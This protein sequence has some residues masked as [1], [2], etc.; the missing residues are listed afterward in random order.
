MSK[1]DTHINDK[2]LNCLIQ[3]PHTILFDCN[4]SWFNL[5]PMNER[6]RVAICDDHKIFR[7]GVISSLKP[8]NNIEIVADTE[9]GTELLKKIHSTSPDIVLLD[10]NMPEMDGLEVC[11]RIKS[12]YPEVHVIGLSL[13]EQVYFIT[14][15]FKAGA[16]S[17][18]LK[19]VDPEEM[20][21][22]M[23]Q[24]YIH[25]FYLHDQIPVDLVKNLV[26]MDHP[27]VGLFIESNEELKERDIALLR[28]ITAEYTNNEIAEKLS[29]SPVTIENYRNQL[30]KKTGARNTAGLVTYAIRK[31]YVI[32]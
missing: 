14:G 13:H 18:L 15:M 8:F 24:V 1:S 10:I 30:L 29:L 9:N 7:N 6:I 26:K 12:K 2:H 27:A 23:Q 28:M 3:Q 22:A 21:H 5:G 20:V 25:G 4:C 31:G 17:Y 19:D 16:G 32:L 11:K